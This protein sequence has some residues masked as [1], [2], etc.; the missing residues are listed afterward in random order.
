MKPS[1]SQWLS[2]QLLPWVGPSLY[3]ACLDPP[4]YVRSKNKKKVSVPKTTEK[5]A[6]VKQ[7]VA[8]SA[9]IGTFCGQEDGERR[10]VVKLEFILSVQINNEH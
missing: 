5:A 2:L 8:A 10:G 7:E 1:L 3:E 6:E 9:A 4:G